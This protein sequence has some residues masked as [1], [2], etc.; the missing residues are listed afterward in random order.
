MRLVVSREADADLLRLVDFLQ[1]H[2]VAASA[3]LVVEV[4]QALETLRQFPGRGRNHGA[5]WRE[6]VVQFGRR[7]YLV[8]YRVSADVVLV[9]RILHSRE[10]R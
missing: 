6:L 4:K 3:R 2:D 8:R 7:P 10:A 1:D 5:G 9:T